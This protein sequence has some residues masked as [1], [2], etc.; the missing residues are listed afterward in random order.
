LP[1]R[2]VLVGGSAENEAGLKDHGCVETSSPKV[3]GQISSDGQGNLT[4]SIEVA[5]DPP[6]YET[7]LYLAATDITE[8]LKEQ[9][10][11]SVGTHRYIM[12][13][14]NEASTIID[15]VP[16][17]ITERM[18]RYVMQ[19][20]GETD[21]F[22]APA[23][24]A[25]TSYRNVVR[26]GHEVTFDGTKRP[27]DL[28]SFLPT[29]PNYESMQVEVEKAAPPYGIAIGERPACAMSPA[30]PVPSERIAALKFPPSMI[31]SDIRLD[32][33]PIAQAAA[34]D[35]SPGGTYALPRAGYL[36]VRRDG[37]DDFTA[38]VSLVLT[39]ARCRQGKP[40]TIALSFTDAPSPPYA[41]IAAFPCSEPN[42]INFT[43]TPAAARV[44]V[45]PNAQSCDPGAAR[46]ACL[47][48]VAVGDIV[49]ASWSQSGY[50][51]LKRVV[52]LTGADIDAGVLDIDLGQPQ[53]RSRVFKY[54]VDVKAPAG[55]TD[56][57]L[58]RFSIKSASMD[59]RRTVFP[60]EDIEISIDESDSIEISFELEDGF[61]L[62]GITPSDGDPQYNRS[63]GV[64]T[65]RVSAVDLPYKGQQDSSA[66]VKV[67]LQYAP[68]ISLDRTF[69]LSVRIAGV[70]RDGGFC[71]VG[72]QP[73]R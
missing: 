48:R 38:N 70:E 27:Y 54:E 63:S 4:G 13:L 5:I 45:P 35:A 72:L 67:A 12:V 3:T 20:N 65:A 73:K 40:E 11:A 69:G 17:E 2:A 52:T 60:K 14:P 62:E 31:A 53:L 46:V 34:G 30:A 56:I 22:M 28:L 10:R 50:V 16:S 47:K 24:A 55:V 36:E 15:G 57:G 58:E 39:D 68:R 44:S 66:L 7:K 21:C 18:F 43:L 61:I 41:E 71:S 64:V 51:P 26:V 42:R 1:A 32:G 37:V 19:P 25:S 59:T 9:A 8:D 33:V 23:V 6:R 49:T 29:V